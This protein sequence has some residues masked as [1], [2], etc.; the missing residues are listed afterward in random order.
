[1]SIQFQQSPA[2]TLG[3][4]AAVSAALVTAVYLLTRAPI[5]AAEARWF[6]HRLSAVLQTPGSA[7]ALVAS[8]AIIE[9]PA[10]SECT[11]CWSDAELVQADQAIY[12]AAQKSASAVFAIPSVSSRGYNGR[13]EVITGVQLVGEQQEPTIVSVEVTRHRETPGIGDRIEAD[14]S[15][16]LAQFRGQHTVAGAD[17]L[18]G[19]TISASAVKAAIDDALRFARANQAT[20]KSHSA[21]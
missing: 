18:S 5:E 1:V 3:L 19:A 16:W 20:L 13:I 7:T 9:L 12:M 2:H 15:Q 11:E 17:A 6:Q 10:P 21:P 4:F 8:E 14:K